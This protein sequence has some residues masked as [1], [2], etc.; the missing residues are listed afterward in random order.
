MKKKIAVYTCITG[1]YDEIAS[2]KYPEKNIDYYCFT[3]NKKLMSDTWKVVYIE[4]NGLSDK[5]LSKKYK[6]LGDKDIE[7][8]YDI[9]I[10]VD[11]NVQAE[12]PYSKII[13]QYCDFDKEAIYFLNHPE[14][15]CAYKEGEEC[16]RLKLDH[17]AIIRNQLKFYKTENFPEKFGLM[18]CG[19]IMRKTK[20]LKLT[21]VLKKWYEQ[22]SNFSQ[23]DQISV[24]Y[25]FWKYSMTYGK[26]D[27]DTYN[28]S[29]FT[30]LP[31]IKERKH[32]IP[33]AFGSGI[34]NYLGLV[35]EENK[36][37]PEKDNYH[38]NIEDENDSQSSIARRVK[39][40]SRVLDIGCGVGIIGE[41]LYKNKECENYGIELDKISYEKAKKSGYY[42]D[43]YN[44]SI[45]N[46]KEFDDFLKKKIK[47][48]YIILAD[49]LEHIKE[50]TEVLYQLIPLLNPDGKILISIPN[51]AY[52]DI[53]R[54]LINREFNYQKTGILDSTHFRFFTRKS[55]AEMIE[56]FN[57]LH[58]IN[59]D[60][61]W[62][63]STKVL[64][65]YHKNVLFQLIDID[66]ESSIVQNIFELTQISKEQIP[67]NLIKLLRKNENNNFYEISK[68]IE[69]IINEKN[70][71]IEQ[72]KVSVLEKD[73][74][75][76]E[77]KLLNDENN[78]L[79]QKNEFLRNELDN[80]LKSKSWKI[81]K[82]LRKIM[83]ILGK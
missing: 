38:C 47:F 6:I 56:N 19:I 81:T 14:R 52:I 80:I 18:S 58:E 13:K 2:I 64:P 25:C 29:V 71:L 27:L 39:D 32:D 44:I 83:E 79:T 77:N 9:V 51:M 68:E 10:Y 59:F 17:P 55:F 75:S 3:N 61:E 60:V 45:E 30:F 69:K 54:A 36:Y 35:E 62:F 46:K 8:K 34:T 24:T 70:D 78:L 41:L 28:N 48:D 53:I 74:L 43:V 67:T 26:I 57:L 31:H 40:K 7:K 65:T 23:R 20:N 72:N 16:I 82:P 15:D 1:N 63:Y 66:N 50:P 49:V 12:L 11:G 5:L 22:V 76:N 73:N 37:E 4:N 33:C 21:K 42:K